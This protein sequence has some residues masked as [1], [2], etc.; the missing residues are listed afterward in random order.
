MRSNQAGSFEE[1]DVFDVDQVATF[2]CER[3]MTRIQGKRARR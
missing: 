3:M 1:S 2:F